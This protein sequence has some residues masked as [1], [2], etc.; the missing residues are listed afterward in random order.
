VLEHVP[1]PAAAVTAGN[2]ILQQ[3]QAEPVHCANAVLYPSL[4]MGA[5]CL[6]A[7]ARTAEELLSQADIAMFH[8]KR[9]RADECVLYSDRIR[10]RG[11]AISATGTR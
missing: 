4:S 8:A 6:G 9:N 2:R 11:T 7:D 10:P 5:S 3:V 1:S